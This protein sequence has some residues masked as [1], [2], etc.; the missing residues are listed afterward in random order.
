MHQT[1]KLL[2]LSFAPLIAFYGFE[3]F[4]GLKTA[5]AATVVVTVAEII[6]RK[7]KKEEL[8]A[9]F[10]F[11]SIS[12][13]GFGLVDV[14]STNTR[15]F[16][17]EPALTNFMT[18][19]YFIWGAITP[20]PLMQDMVMKMKKIPESHF[21]P[22]IV[23][24]FRIMTWIWVVYFLVKAGVYYAIA[25]EPDTS[26]GKMMIIRTLVGNASMFGMIGI[27]WL[28]GKPLLKYIQKRIDGQTV[29]AP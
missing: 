18:G 28:I 15:F 24:Y 29:G 26:V 2:I 9:F 4:F 22:A 7:L 12:T 20:K 14:C 19:A 13:I 10:W 27:S 11:V 23:M 21:G 25:D 8:G 3:H 16:K 1:F 17:Y 6:Y 5:I